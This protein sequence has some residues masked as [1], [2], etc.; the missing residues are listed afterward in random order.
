LDEFKG[1]PC[2]PDPELLDECIDGIDD[3]TCAE[4]VEGELPTVCTHMCTGG[5]CEGVECD[6]ENECTDDV[7]NPANGSCEADPLPDGTPC[8]AGGC[9]DGV[10]VSVF[11]CSEAGIRAAVET[12]GGPYR[13]DCDI[14]TSVATED[15]IFIEKDVVLD[16]EGKL[17]LDGGDRHRLFIVREGVTAELQGFILTAGRAEAAGDEGPPVHGGGAVHNAGTLVISDTTVSNSFAPRWL[18]L[19]GRGGG[20]ANTGTLALANVTVT[21]NEAGHGGGIDSTGDLTIMHSM[22]SDNIGGGIGAYGGLTM[23]DSAISSNRAASDGGG[24]AVGPGEPASVVRCTLSGNRGHHGGGVYNYG[25]LTVTDSILSQND[26]TGVGGGIH[27]T[28]ELTVSNSTV[29]DNDGGGIHSSGT[30]RLVALTV[31]GN[32]DGGISI[33]RGTLTLVDSTVSGNSSSSGGGGIYS[34]GL[35]TAINSTISGN[36]AGYD[37]GGIRSDAPMVLIHA[38]VSGN[39]AAEGGDAIS[40]NPG[41]DLPSTVL[42]SLVD[43]NCQGKELASG[44]YNI[45]SPGDTCGFGQASDLTQRPPEEIN[46][47]PLQ[48]NGGPTVTHALLREPVVSVAID[49]IPAGDCINADGEPLTTDQ[50][51]FPRD[52][53]CDVGAFEVQP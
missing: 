41:P 1:I 26:A 32:S 4:I 7:C 15:T 30:S 44:G 39:S 29:A 22:V 8:S 5:L 25:S 52:A 16:G 9:Q 2:E 36:E 28:G 51:G 12:G 43:G 46:L 3:L 24:L 19:P 48:D 40:N 47:G 6:D 34:M 35:L 33:E 23:T 21:G 53:T 31:S 13:F 11:S 18:N 17:T 37:G 49:V 27:S 20:I 10:C 38:T 14:G 50:R 42:N 45:E